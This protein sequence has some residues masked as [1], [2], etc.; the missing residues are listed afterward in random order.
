M[1]PVL[2][3][4]LVCVLSCSLIDALVLYSMHDSA[5]CSKYVEI[6]DFGINFVLRI[7]IHTWPF[8]VVLVNITA[9]CARWH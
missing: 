7:A 9:K 1:S 2:F 5:K 4:L 6:Q 3:S 8:I